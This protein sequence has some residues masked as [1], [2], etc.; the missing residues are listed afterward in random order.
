M[1]CLPGQRSRSKHSFRIS[2]HDLKNPYILYRLFF[3]KTVVLTTLMPVVLTARL[4]FV[5]F[6]LGFTARQD[7]F[8][9]FEPS[10]S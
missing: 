3:M 8:T 2:V 5:F 7:Y 1:L 9:H 10:Q 4:D 6:D